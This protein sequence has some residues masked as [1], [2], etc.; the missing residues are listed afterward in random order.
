MSRWRSRLLIVPVLV[1]A[2]YAGRQ[3]EVMLARD[4]SNKFESHGGT[5]A[6]TGQGAI[7]FIWYSWL[8]TLV[9]ERL[10]G[11]VLYK[12]KRKTINIYATVLLLPMAA[13]M[14]ST[15]VLMASTLRTLVAVSLRLI[16]LLQLGEEGRRLAIDSRPAGQGY[17]H[18]MKT[19][20]D[21]RFH[22]PA[23]TFLLPA[24]ISVE[25]RFY[26]AID[27]IPSSIW[28]RLFNAR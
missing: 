10:Q 19:I 14:A 11:F 20:D 5:T 13:L 3:K 25:R 6:S 22:H 2:V 9:S 26:R 7:S 4:S 23:R 21:P 24:N 18:A 17:R 27:G 1:R 12:M 8:L 15:T 28:A 16:P